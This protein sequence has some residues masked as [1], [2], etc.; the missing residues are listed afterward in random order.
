MDIGYGEHGDFL[1]GLQ[2]NG[3]FGRALDNQWRAVIPE[4][5]VH[6]LDIW[7]AEPMSNPRGR[8]PNG[9]TVASKSRD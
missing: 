5:P 6:Y 9:P 8:A 4:H 7:S 1:L 3:R 2:L